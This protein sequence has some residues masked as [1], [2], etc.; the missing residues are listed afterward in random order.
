M[1]DVKGLT[2]QHITQ[3]KVFRGVDSLGTETWFVKWSIDTKTHDPFSGRTFGISGG[4]LAEILHKL[5]RLLPETIPD[6]DSE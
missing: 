6:P 2:E 4:S 1:S 5:Q 3:I